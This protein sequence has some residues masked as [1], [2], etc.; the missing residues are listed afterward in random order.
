MK[1]IW[2]FEVIG[3][4]YGKLKLNMPKEAEILSV[5]IQNERPQIWALV[6]DE[7][8]IEER[9]FE[10]FG[11]G[12]NITGDMGVERKYIGT[13]QLYNGTLV[14]HLFERIS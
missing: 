13:F 12:H 9:F 8:E 10:I 1:T 5:Q 2:K 4:I 11:T 3:D 14:F 6:N 7:A